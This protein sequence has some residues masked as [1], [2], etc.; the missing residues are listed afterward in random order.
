MAALSRR[1]SKIVVAM[2]ETPRA[3]QPDFHMKSRRE[4]SF[5][6]CLRRMLVTLL[7]SEDACLANVGDQFTIRSCPRV[8]RA[9]GSFLRGKLRRADDQIDRRLSARRLLRHGQVAHWVDERKDARPHIC[10]H[11]PLHEQKAEAIE[12]STAD[13][14]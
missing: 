1:R 5:S 11:V 6:F 10:R 13:A 2:L 4:K 14:N 8:P 9:R 7:F 12:Q 3:A